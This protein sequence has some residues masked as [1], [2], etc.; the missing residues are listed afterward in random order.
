MK[1]FFLLIVLLG[2]NLCVYSQEQTSQKVPDALTLEETARYALLNNFGQ[3]SLLLSKMSSEA[4]YL[5]SKDQRLPGLSASASQGVSN[6]NSTTSWTGNYSLSTNMTLYSGGSL[7]KTIEQNK[8]KVEQADAQILQS[9]NQLS[10]QVIQAFLSVLMNEEILKYQKVVLKTSEENLNQ[11][12]ET[13]KVGKILESDYMLLESQYASDKYNVVNTE[14]NRNN[15]ILALKNLL[16][17]APEETFR[18]IPPDTAKV[19]DIS[20]LPDMGYVM[21][22]TL[23]WF[24]DLQISRQ[25]IDLAT[26]NVELAQASYFPTVSLSGSLGTGYSNGNGGFGTQLGDRLNESLSIGV[27]IPIFNRNQT[28]TQVLQSK[29][30]LKKA[31]LTAKQ[32]ELD[33][34]QEIEKEYQTV[35]A[36]YNKYVASTVKERAYSES[37]RVYGVQYSEGSITTVDLLQ[38]QSN[39]LSALNEYLQ[40][41]YSFI[42]NRKILD[43]YMGMPIQL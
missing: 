2:F 42:L 8:L 36:A 7:N 43:V 6:S 17:M 19:Y 38:Q 4:S 34:K 11:G 40:N 37:F 27:S 24:P 33:V 21:E 22:K 32:T 9:E 25:N 20:D 41:K 3:Q 29:Y 5:Q 16:S 30:S 39:Y 10:I 31:E 12:K 14:I 28:K 26:L 15:S 35:V 1:Q 18:I 13:F 23:A